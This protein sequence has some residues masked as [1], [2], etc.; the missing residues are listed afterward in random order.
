VLR[1]MDAETTE[2]QVEAVLRQR[3]RTMSTP[4][5]G[6]LSLADDFQGTVAAFWERDRMPPRPLEFVPD[7]DASARS[8]LA[9]TVRGGDCPGAGGDGEPTERAELHE[10]RAAALPIGTEA[11]YGISLYLPP[12]FPVVDRRLV[13]GQWY[14]P[15]PA[16]FRSPLVANR[17]RD[18]RFSI[19]REDGATRLVCFE[20]PR[21][22]RGRW[23]D[24]VYHVRFSPTPA[25]LLEAWMDGR[26]V[27]R[28]QGALGYSDGGER[29]HFRIGLYRDHLPMPM[30]MLIR[31]FRRGASIADQRP[32]R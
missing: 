4:S 17:Y 11:W 30:T 20:E 6:P 18:G 31:H 5:S 10:T 24:L 1:L 25:G 27:V 21:E 8:V 32:L 3:E 23:L 28:Y 7:P 9:I 2:S 13:L 15:H 16:P 22:I 29:V 14:Q 12:D 26:Q 19:T